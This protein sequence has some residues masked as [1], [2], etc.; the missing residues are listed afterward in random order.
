MNISLPSTGLP[1]TI[2]GP[3]QW[4]IPCFLS[5]FCDFFLRTALSHSFY[6]LFFSAPCAFLTPTCQ[7][8]AYSV[9]LQTPHSFPLLPFFMPPF[10]TKFCT[11]PAYLAFLPAFPPHLPSVFALL[12]TALVTR[13]YVTS[14][15]IF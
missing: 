1:A 5:T 6:I 11:S 9:S 3:S 15:L 8:F 13:A 2:Q 14:D 7:P 4:N 10:P 12:V